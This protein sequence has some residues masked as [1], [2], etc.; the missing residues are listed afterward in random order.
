MYTRS[1]TDHNLNRLTAAENS[2]NFNLESAKA[3]YE[4]NLIES[5]LPQS[6]PAVYQYLRSIT[7]HK[8][9]TATIVFN[10]THASSDYNKANLFNNYFHSVFTKDS[11]A[12]SDLPNCLHPTNYNDSR[13]F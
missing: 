1:P 4:A 8:G 5:L 13:N 2:F 6:N 3:T 10:D 7:N 9:I 11:Y 12:T